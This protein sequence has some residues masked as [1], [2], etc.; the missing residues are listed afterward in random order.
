MFPS[1]VLGM[2]YS[3]VNG[4]NRL[5]EELVD[6]ALLQEYSHAGCLPHRSSQNLAALREGRSISLLHRE[7]SRQQ[8][9]AKICREGQ[10]LLWY[11]GDP[12]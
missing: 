6:L 8:V 4:K 9:T 11:P 2:V 3:S 10:L 12:S 1:I 7:S 5:Q